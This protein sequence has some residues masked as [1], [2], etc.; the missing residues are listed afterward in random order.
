M[1]GAAYPVHWAYRPIQPIVPPK[2]KNEKRVSNT[3]DRYVLAKLEKA[4]QTP[5]PKADRRTLAK[6]L[7]YDLLGLSPTSARVEAFVKDQAPDAYTKL[8][9][10]LLKS[11]HFGE[12]WGRHWLDMARYA[13]S[14]G[15]EKDKAR[16]NAWRYRDWVIEAINDDL[17][18]D[19]FT[20]EQL[21]AI[22][23][24]RPPTNNAS[25]PPFTVR[26]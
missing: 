21:A 2:L 11:P 10:E 15:Y 24:P 5:S 9:D 26:P 25:R 3:I 17:P 18:Y 16:P 23:C 22:C 1:E 6:R 20:V 7:H 8:V 14:D 4:G 19:Q 12:R 13:D